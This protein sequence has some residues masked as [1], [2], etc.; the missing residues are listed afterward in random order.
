MRFAPA[1]AAPI[2]YWD[3]DK[4]AV[5]TEKVYGDAPMRWLYGTRAGQLLADR[6]LSGPIPSRLYGAYQSSRASA[7]Q[8]QAFIGA[9]GI[10]MGEYENRA[11]SSFNDFFT[12]QFRPGA[13]KFVMTPNRMPAFC[14]AR[15]LAFDRVT[16][17]LRFPVKGSE[18]SAGAVLGDRAISRSF[19]GGPMLLAR[20][21]PT[22]YHRF[23]YPDAGTVIENHRI[24]GKLHSVN[25][26]ALRY[27]GGILATNERHVSVLKTEN[28]GRLAYVEV[29]ALCVGKIVQTHPERLT[30]NRGDEKGCFLFGASTVMLFGEKGAWVPDED[31]LEQ[32][33][34]RRETFVKLGTAVARTL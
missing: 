20:L 4:Q 18:L 31:L 13:R 9:F 24:A 12:R 8:I 28:F 26:M 5:E 6:L 15:Y 1:P 21:C 10:D 23:H 19:E 17:W 2:R 16:P 7:R 25:P 32:T 14:E 22:D 30:F 29:G 33:A 34:K 27:K 3:R 11:F